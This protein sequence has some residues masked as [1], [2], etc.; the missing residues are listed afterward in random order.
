MPL[1]REQTDELKGALQLGIIAHHATAENSN[2]SYSLEA[3]LVLDT[4]MFLFGFVQ[5]RRLM[6]NSCLTAG[7]FI[8]VSNRNQTLHSN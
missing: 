8:L 1:Y 7:T 3:Q 2:R 4:F 5:F 6:N